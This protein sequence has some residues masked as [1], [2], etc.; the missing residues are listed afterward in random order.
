MQNIFKFKKF[1]VL[2]EDIGAKIGTDGV[3]LGAWVNIK[4]DFKTFLDV[5]TGTGVIALMLAQRSNKIIDAIE[6][7]SKACKLAEYNFK[8]AYWGKHLNIIKGDFVMFNF[9]KK[10]DC[11][12]ANPPFYKN[13]YP[14]KDRQRDMARNE[15]FLSFKDLIHKAAK[16]LTKG[17]NFSIIVPYNYEAEILSIAQRVGLYAHKIT[18]VKGMA[19][20]KTKRSLICF[21]F[22]EAKTEESLLII[23]KER[24][25]YTTEYINLVKDFYL[26]M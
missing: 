20:A 23:E 21:S 14:V 10:Y 16:I 2:Q 19:T 5:G 4:K 22:M 12:V 13:T 11:I 24:H 18:R 25:I 15:A 7:D 8:N 3:L 1:E 17:G 9:T 26:K 6:I